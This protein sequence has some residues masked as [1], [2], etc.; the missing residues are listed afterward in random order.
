M[1]MYKI[2]ISVAEIRG[3]SLDVQTF[4]EPCFEQCK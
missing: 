2:M 3:S 4:K 1:G